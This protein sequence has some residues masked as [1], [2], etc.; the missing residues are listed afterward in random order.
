MEMTV[1]VEAF[2]RRIPR[3]AL[4]GPVRWSDG[5]VRGPR[6]LPMRFG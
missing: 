4:D 6:N 1:A 3:F 5:T 2:L